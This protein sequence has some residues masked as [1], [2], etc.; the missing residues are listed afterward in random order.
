LI[1]PMMIQN[2]G[3]TQELSHYS[4]CNMQRITRIWFVA[5][6]WDFLISRTLLTVSGAHAS[7]YSVGGGAS[8][9]FGGGGGGKAGGEKS[10]PPPPPLG[11][12]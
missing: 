8:L 7:S 5:R 1:K 11:Q 9:F 3:G 4:D 10:C 6:V 12:G 2:C